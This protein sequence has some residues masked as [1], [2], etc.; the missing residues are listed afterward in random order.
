MILSPMRLP[1]HHLRSIRNAPFVV[2]DTRNHF[3]S[4]KWSIF[5]ATEL[6][7]LSSM[8]LNHHCNVY[9]MFLETCQRGRDNSAQLDG[10][11]SMCQNHNCDAY[12]MFLKTYQ[13]GREIRLTKRHHYGN[14]TMVKEALI[15]APIERPQ[16][17]EATWK[18]LTFTTT[19]ID[20]IS[21][22]HA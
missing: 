10:L 5:T 16:Q 13:R 18:E 1:C 7:G 17:H 19:S 3:E 20:S 15:Y 12:K 11:S 6:D 4:K 22:T 8:C 9:K 2:P 14:Q 21:S